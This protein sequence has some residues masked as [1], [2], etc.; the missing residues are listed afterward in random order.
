MN[1]RDTGKTAEPPSPSEERAG[2]RLQSSEGTIYSINLIPIGGFVRIL[3]ENNDSQ[4]HPGS[5]INKGFWPRFL[6][7]VAG[8][9]MNVIL[10]WVLLSVGYIIG[11]PVGVNSV[12]EIPAHTVFI[13]PQTAITLVVPGESADKAGLKTDDIILKIDSQSFSQIADIQNYVKSHE[14]QSIVFNI[15]RGRQDINIPVTPKLNP[16]PDEG[17]TGIELAIVGKLKYPWYYAVWEGG[18]T[19]V[20]SLKQV[21]W[22]MVQLFGGKVSLSNVGGPVKI[23]RLVGQ[24]RQSGFT[25]VLFLTV[26]LSL[27]LAVLNIL[28]F[29]A[30]D[31]GR[32]LFLLIETVRRKKNNPKVEQIVNTAGFIFLIL[33]MVAVT[34]HD[35]MR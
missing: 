2:E 31:G 4:E 17:P 24:A 25:S 16:G 29:P 15:Q 35:I 19:T 21:A 5:F 34:I 27:S 8:V 11:L 6:T 32:V 28:P 22:G 9:I 7:L 30:L 3:G 18:K 10:A 13:N 14:G 20:S 23:A 1:V 33:L 26:M 12:S